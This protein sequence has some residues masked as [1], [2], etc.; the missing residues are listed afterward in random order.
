MSDT[1]GDVRMKSAHASRVVYYYKK[2]IVTKT[3]SPPRR[4]LV[5][6]YVGVGEG[7]FV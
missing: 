1:G 3:H 5:H 7:F 4:G 6:I 2:I